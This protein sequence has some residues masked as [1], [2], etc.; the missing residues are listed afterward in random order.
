MRLNVPIPDNLYI[1]YKDKVGNISQDITNYVNNI[2]KIPNKRAEIE[3]K[4][5]ENQLKQSKIVAELELLNN[6]LKDLTSKQ[7]AEQKEKFSFDPFAHLQGKNKINE[8]QRCLYKTEK[9]TFLPDWATE[10]DSTNPKEFAIK[11]LTQLNDKL[12]E[13]KQ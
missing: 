4:I 1:L 11:L 3:E 8:V 7:E 6:S 10:R 5:K 12:K 2:V 13:S 9:G